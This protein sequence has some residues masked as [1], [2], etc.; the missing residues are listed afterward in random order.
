[1]SL[2]RTNRTEAAPEA[3]QKISD[4]SK[5]PRMDDTSDV[6][7]VSAQAAGQE[8]SAATAAVDSAH[9][10]QF[11]PHLLLLYQLASM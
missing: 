11:N 8:E 4:S 6:E 10:A 9:L 3:A 7:P 2:L 1:M 5:G